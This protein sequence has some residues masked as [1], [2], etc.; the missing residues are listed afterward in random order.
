MKQIILDTN[1]LMIPATLKV[2]IFEEIKR[3]MP[4]LHELCI[5]D[6]TLDELN[7]IIKEQ[8]GK[9]KMAASIGHQLVKQ[10]NIKVLKTEK[11]LNT[12]K[13]I[14]NLAKGPDFIV[15]TQD[16]ALK[17]E[18][19]KKGVKLIVLRQKKYLALI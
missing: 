17:D 2:D 9:Y 7:T 15:A 14:V 6:K 11:N 5:V 19:K 4:E 3:I 10:K 8:R 18:L 12:D 13:P 16:K 1:F